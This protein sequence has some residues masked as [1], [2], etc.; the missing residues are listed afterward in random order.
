MNDLYLVLNDTGV[1][2]GIFTWSKMLHNFPSESWDNYNFNINQ[3]VTVN[4]ERYKLRV[5]QVMINQDMPK[6]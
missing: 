5:M 4:T 2:L 3:W 1:P 6:S